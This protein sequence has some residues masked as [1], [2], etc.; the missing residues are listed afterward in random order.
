MVSSN[1]RRKRLTDRELKKL[2][3]K[4][5]LNSLLPLAKSF[6][7]W[8]VLVV[9]V[10]WDYT[11]FRWF[12]MAFVHFTTYLSYGLS[13]LLFIPV[14]LLGS[15]SSMM[16]TLEVNYDSITI[17][18]FPMLI[19]LECSA[20]HA[21]IA[22]VALI[23]FSSWTLKNKLLWGSAIFGTLAIINSLRI[24]LLGVIGNKYPTAFNIM[25]D[26]IWNILMVI[27]LW[28]LWELINNKFTKQA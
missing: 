1:I 28:G 5:L 24:V 13:K 8:I 11:S 4:E 25:H 10:A 14:R 26:Y 7:T 22:M 12:S 2:Q 15:S 6:G 27:I 20:Y 18:G 19:E 23:I 3:Q 17:S 9:I 21:Y 16:T